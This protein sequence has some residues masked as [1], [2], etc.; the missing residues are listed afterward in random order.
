MKKPQPLN[1]VRPHSVILIC[2]GI[3]IPL[4]IAI[5]ATGIYKSSESRFAT[6]ILQND[7]S[8]KQVSEIQASIAAQMS[9]SKAEILTP[10]DAAE[11]L[12]SKSKVDVGNLGISVAELPSRIRIIP[13]L[14]FTFEYVAGD[15][16]EILLGPGIETFVIPEKHD[17]FF[18]P[19]SV[20]LMIAL[21][22]FL[23]FLPL[24]WISLATDLRSYSEESKRRIQLMTLF[25]REDS[26]MKNTEAGRG[27]KEGIMFGIYSV[28]ILLVSVIGGHVLFPS[29]GIEFQGSMLI[30]SL[31]MAPLLII[32]IL[33]V[34]ARRRVLGEFL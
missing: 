29:I 21:I 4:I 32:P 30:W 27:I 13:Q 5:F 20:A 24:V 6:L 17:A 23:I 19:A 7:V 25:G 3:C 2:M 26:E 14:G 10:A 8:S 31:V 34:T 15:I 1:H 33:S 22:L 18:A 11:F 9:V 16:Q 28:A 12:N